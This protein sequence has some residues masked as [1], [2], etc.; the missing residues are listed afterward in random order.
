[1]HLTVR[2]PRPAGRRGARRGP[3][4]VSRGRLLAALVAAAA[5]ACRS[6]DA[7]ADGPYEPILSFDTACVRIVTAADTARL[8]VEVAATEDQRM[9]GLMERRALAAD[10]GILFVYP[11]TQPD[12][13][14]FWMFRTR[15]PLDIAFIDSAGVVR[16]I[17]AMAPCES[18]V[19]RA[20]PTYP[21]GVPFRAALEVNRGYFG[22]HGVRVGDR[23]PLADL[24]GVAPAPPHAAP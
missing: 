23:V 7:P 21:A 5:L 15:L 14:A 2:K 10:A 12:S 24:P 19:A 9:V 18:P 11:A 6:G 17:Q 13:A 4:A 16:A 22:R 3:S 1:M 20:C 8:V